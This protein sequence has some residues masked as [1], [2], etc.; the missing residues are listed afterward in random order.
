VFDHVPMA[1]QDLPHDLTRDPSHEG[2]APS[3]VVALAS[4]DVSVMAWGL[5]ASGRLVSGFGWLAGMTRG[6]SSRYRFLGAV[7]TGT[8]AARGVEVAA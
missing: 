4:F 7:G 1:R 8:V 6:H 3:L 5:L 2:H